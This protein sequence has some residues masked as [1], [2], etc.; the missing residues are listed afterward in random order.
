MCSLRDYPAGI[1]RLREP[2]SPDESIAFM[3][4][5][6]SVMKNEMLP[7]DHV[8]HFSAVLNGEEFRT[9]LNR[10]FVEEWHWGPLEEL[11][12]RPFKAHEDRCTFEV[13]GRTGE[14]WRSVIGKIHSVD[15]SDSFSALQALVRS[16]F[17]PQSEFSISQPLAYL[18]SLH[19]LIE[20]KIQGKWVMEVFLDGTTEEQLEAAR[21][22]GAW[23]GRFHTIAPRVGD[24]DGPGDLLA[25]IHYYANQ[26]RK[27]GESFA[28][29][30]DTLL[31]RIESA[32]PNSAAIDFRAGHGSFIPEHVFLN[33][34]RT[35][36]I[37]IDE[38]DIAD[39]SRDLA[40]FAVSL[41]RLGLKKLGSIRERDTVVDEFLGA[42]REARGEQTMKNFPF[43]KAAECLHRA[44]RDLY[45]R[46]TPIPQWADIMLNEGLR[47]LP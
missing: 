1:R 33:G 25:S 37:D 34:T 28:I 29:K 21:R 5:A 35:I 12:L 2:P 18:P 45:K 40:W 41:Q 3:P 14:M 9:A 6:M 10:L 13:S 32:K 8:S 16:G 43:F 42:Y 20:E 36:V 4:D 24:I 38:H 19:I 30:S 44:H 15:R 11:R 22:S 17:G 47:I 27:F 39:P 46:E 31:Q 26:V 23:L 7:E